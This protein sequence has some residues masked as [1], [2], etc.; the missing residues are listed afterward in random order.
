MN[1]ALELGAVTVGLTLLAASAP[2]AQAQTR[3]SQTRRPYV[4]QLPP[5]PL[6]SQ[7]LGVLERDFAYLRNTSPN[8]NSFAGGRWNPQYRVV[9][10]PRYQPDYG[11]FPPNYGYYPPGYGYGYYQP[12]YSVQ[13]GPGYGYF[14]YNQPYNQQQSVVQREV[15]V[16]REGQP[17]DTGRREEPARRPESSGGA[18][19]AEKRPDAAPAGDDFYLRGDRSEGE[20]ISTALDDIRKAWLNGDFARLQ[21][22]FKA[23]GKVRVFPQGEYKYAVETKDFLALVKTA[24]D[25]IDT[26]A[27]E[28]E[29][30]K[31]LETNR[32][33]VAGK[34][35]FT[36]ADK[37]RRE[38][39]ISYVLERAAGKDARWR[40]V[41]AGSSATPIARHA[42]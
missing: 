10:P 27:F 26:S 42:E 12:G 15:V 40:I 25:R 24:M 9:N 14:Q 31:A 33:F 17:A 4:Q 28:L 36:D 23:D 13:V 1:R 3:Q 8:P 29:R 39:H 34:H 32:V 5:E 16:I 18:G 6:G 37:A 11:Y 20:A 30:P 21:A 2:S 38:T 35:T 41:E 7:S 19:L 22:R